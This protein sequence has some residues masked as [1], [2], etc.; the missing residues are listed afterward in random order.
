M[1]FVGGSD[2]E[3]K[4]PAMLLAGQSSEGQRLKTRDYMWQRFLLLAEDVWC[5]D[6][7]GQSLVWEVRDLQQW[8]HR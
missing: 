3:C 4:A 6:H 5:C 2:A 8:T 7:P 1:P